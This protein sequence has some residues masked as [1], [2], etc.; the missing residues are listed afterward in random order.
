MGFGKL[1]GGFTGNRTYVAAEKL[2]Y[3]S[4]GGMAM[5]TAATHLQHLTTNLWVQHTGYGII[6]L[7][8]EQ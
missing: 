3:D 6:Q 7:G 1:K 5:N 8:P 4:V 2:V